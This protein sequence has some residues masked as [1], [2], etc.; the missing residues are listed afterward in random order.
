MPEDLMSYSLLFTHLLSL[1]L[2]DH[3]KYQKCKLVQDY[4]YKKLGELYMSNTNAILFGYDRHLAN[5]LIKII[6]NY[7]TKQENMDFSEKTIKLLSDE[8]DINNEIE[9]IV[10]ESAEPR[11]LKL[12]DITN[13]RP[14][15]KHKIFENYKNSQENNIFICCFSSD[16][17]LKEQDEI[18]LKTI[19][20][21]F[22]EV[23]LNNFFCIIDRSKL[24][25]DEDNEYLKSSAD[26]VNGKLGFLFK[27]K[28]NLF[29][30]NKY[31]KRVFFINL[32]RIFE[33][34]QKDDISPLEELKELGGLNFLT[35]LKSF[36]E[37]IREE[38][39]LTMSETIDVSSEEEKEELK[40]PSELADGAITTAKIA[41]D[42]ITGDKIKDQTITKDKLAF[43]LESG[44]SQWESDKNGNGIYYRQ[45][46]KA[47]G[48]NQEP[49]D[50]KLEVNG[51]IKL[52][53]GASLYVPGARE[54]LM[55]LRGSFPEGFETE[56]QEQKF[57]Y[58]GS[59]FN[60]EMKKAG[61]YEIKFHTPFSEPPT[62][63]VTQ[64][65]EPESKL[66]NNP[67]N[68]EATAEGVILTF[69]EIKLSDIFG[70]NFYSGNSDRTLTSIAGIRF[71]FIAVGA[72]A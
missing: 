36:W 42:S 43:S 15:L 58:R 54:N 65:H 47:V 27:N 10:Y 25:D 62:V 56:R 33:I 41:N 71:E 40:F 38:G 34:C 35:E 6:V 19:Y 16:Y 31:Q 60:V 63:F 2:L 5:K 8:E 72:R 45:H 9:D 68:I 57:I 18:S 24:N 48:I 50:E 26:Y 69:I 17:L 67:I 49:G 37:Q 4:V 46:G 13:K 44:N 70:S 20:T 55:I 64:N 1:P 3:A 11:A 32:E 66:F 23:G 14:E 61:V 21:L 7:F 51:N 53:L 29:D 12:I 22:Q 28:Q 30:N 52:G 59:D 39:N